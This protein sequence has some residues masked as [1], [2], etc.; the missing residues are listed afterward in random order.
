M[1]TLTKWNPLLQ[2]VA[3]LTIIG[4]IGGATYTFASRIGKVESAVHYNTQNI[5]I[6]IEF[7]NRGDRFTKN[8]GNNLE[9]RTDAIEK[10]IMGA[11]PEM[12]NELRS[13]MK[14]LQNQIRD[15]QVS[16]T[17]VNELRLEIKDLKNQVRD[18]QI[19]TEIMKDLQSQVQNNALDDSSRLA[20]N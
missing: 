19:A 18:L 20:A 8:D 4:I 12:V 6:L 16:T 3:M 2:M 14:G 10:W 5:E 1:E 11:F 17:M 9:R 15:L 7:K 13:E